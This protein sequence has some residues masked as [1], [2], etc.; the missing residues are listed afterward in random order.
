MPVRPLVMVQSVGTEEGE[1]MLILE[2]YWK[3]FVEV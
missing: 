1:A 3:L 2:E